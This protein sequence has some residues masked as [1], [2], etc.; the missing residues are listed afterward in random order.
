VNC[1]PIIQEGEGEESK[2]NKVAD[3]MYFIYINQKNKNFYSENKMHDLGRP[4]LI[5]T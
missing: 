1:I 4:R 5:L 2:L 3:R